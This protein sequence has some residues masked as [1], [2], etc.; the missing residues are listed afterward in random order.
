MCSQSCAR[1]SFGVIYEDQAV[2]GYRVRS[3]SVPK[4]IPQ[5]VKRDVMQTAENEKGP[6][7]RASLS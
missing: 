1:P 7:S 4:R 5:L 3:V 6:V 2:P